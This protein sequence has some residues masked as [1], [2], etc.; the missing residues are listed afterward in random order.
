[1][2][3]LTNI[4][5][6][7]SKPATTAIHLYALCWNEARMLPHFFRHYDDIV[8]R[9]F[10]FDNG[11]TD[12]SVQLL[13]QHPRVTLNQFHVKGSSFVRAAQEFNNGCWKSS[14]GEADWVIVCNIDEHLFHGD[15]RGYLAA[16]QR[17]GISLITPRGFEM[18]SDTFPTGSQRLC[19]Q[20]RRGMRSSGSHGMDKPQLFA[21]DHIR[22]INFG[23]GRH[24]ADPTGHVKRPLTKSVKLL[25]YKYLGMDYLTGRLTELGQGM[26]DEDIERKWGTQYSW[27]D[28]EKREQ[29]QKV[30]STAVQ[31][32]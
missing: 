17:R 6:W 3:H 19:E 25:H 4:R 12:S 26:L 28:H 10:I 7:F 14:R 32:T 9:Y 13:E 16:C 11:S 23:V 31:V 18:I 20:V 15:L 30:R 21:P 27:D 2:G 24:S 29:F 1:M 22:E 8:D 5:A